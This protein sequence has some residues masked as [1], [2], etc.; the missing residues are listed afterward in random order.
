MSKHYR[1]QQT[2]SPALVQAYLPACWDEGWVLQP[3]L[4]TEAATGVKAKV[5]PRHIPDHLLQAA[6]VQIG[7]RR[8]G[9]DETE[10]A[11]LRAVYHEGWTPGELSAH[12]QVPS[13]QIHLTCTA[14]IARIAAY[15]SGRTP[16]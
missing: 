11:C 2:Y 6:D 7:Y 1:D 5:D 12:W 14:A 8:A 9:L 10:K 16:K 15:L 13:E 4:R 3:R